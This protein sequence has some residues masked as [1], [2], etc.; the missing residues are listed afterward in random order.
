MA[1]NYSFWK[2]QSC[3]LERKFKY[4]LPILTALLQIFTLGYSLFILFT[5]NVLIKCLY[6]N[7]VWHDNLYFYFAHTYIFRRLARI[8]FLCNNYNYTGVA[9]H[10]FEILRKMHNEI[11]LTGARCNEQ[12]V[13]YTHTFSVYYYMYGI[14]LYIRV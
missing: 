8:W 10:A 4:Y 13:T 7:S 6:I 3:Y 11:T 9:L 5:L 12:L 1:W 14:W 2:C